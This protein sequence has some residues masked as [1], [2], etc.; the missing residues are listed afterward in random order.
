M[1]ARAARRLAFLHSSREIRPVLIKVPTPACTTPLHMG[2]T[3]AMPPYRRP[4]TPT[5]RRAMLSCAHAM[6]CHPTH[7]VCIPSITLLGCLPV[8]LS[9]L[10]SDVDRWLRLSAGTLGTRLRGGEHLD[11]SLPPWRCPPSHPSGF[12]ADGARFPEGR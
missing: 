5:P 4:P 2:R 3:Q 10:R 1:P 8:C 9:G 12:H 6:P 7:Q 11:L